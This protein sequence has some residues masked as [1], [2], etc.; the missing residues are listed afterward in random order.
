TFSAK[1]EQKL[2]Q[3]CFFHPELIRSQVIDDAVDRV[4]Q[5]AKQH[6]IGCNPQLSHLGSL[7]EHPH[8]P[9]HSRKLSPTNPPQPIVNDS[10]QNRSIDL[11]AISKS[12]QFGHDPIR[13]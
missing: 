12:C 2:R 1:M 4:E 3:Q 5:L 10:P 8:Q 11:F 7:V 6:H 9:S 13:I